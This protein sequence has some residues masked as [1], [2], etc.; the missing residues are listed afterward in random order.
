M[1]MAGCFAALP[2]A[3]LRE[4]MAH[5]DAIEDYLYP[6]DGDDEPPNYADV[7]KA[8][9]AIHFMLTGVAE[10][11]DGPF[12]LAVL[13]GTPVGEEVGYGP[14]RFLNPGEVRSVAAA[15]EQLGEGGFRARFDAEAMTRAKIYPDVIW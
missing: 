5:P 8:W 7:D 3:T 4:L 2:P 1:G 10:G 11:G 13:G 6:N 9:H 15:L 14:A 12:A